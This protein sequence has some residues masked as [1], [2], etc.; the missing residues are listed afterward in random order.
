MNPKP[1]IRAQVVEIMKKS[2][3]TGGLAEPVAAKLA[4]GLVRIAVETAERTGE[5]LGLGEP[6]DAAIE[7]LLEELSA[8]L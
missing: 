7:A 4:E 2:F 6:D 1:E 5:P 8:A 3:V